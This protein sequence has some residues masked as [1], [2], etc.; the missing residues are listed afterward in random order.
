MERIRKIV[1]SSI[2]FLI[3]FT[4]QA[5]AQELESGVVSG[6]TFTCNFLSPLD[7]FSTDITFKENG[8]MSFSGFEGN[9]FYLTINN[10]IAG[11]YWSLDAKIGAKSGDVFFLISGISFD[12]F[13]IGAGF[14]VI[15]YSEVY[16]TTFFGLREAE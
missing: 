6:K 9:G 5:S 8:W 10:F 14:L 12:P 11:T 2:I 7:T 3:V 13:I 15:E 4:G 16:F 1:F